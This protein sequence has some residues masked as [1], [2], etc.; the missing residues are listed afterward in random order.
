MPYQVAIAA[1]CKTKDCSGG[2][3]F[4]AR[5]IDE[6]HPEDIPDWMRMFRKEIECPICKRKFTYTRENLR[7][8]PL[9]DREEK[10]GDTPSPN[11]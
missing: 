4:G 3:T 10:Q 9:K 2:F 5:T 1:I 6:K 8:F 7:E 11:S